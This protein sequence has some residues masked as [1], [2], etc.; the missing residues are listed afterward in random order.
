[1]NK[2][3]YKN[4]FS[5]QNYDRILL[6]I[7]KGMGEEW[8]A[9][10]KRRNMSLNAMVQEAVNQYLL[11]SQERIFTMDISKAITIT[12]SNIIALC[13]RHNITINELMKILSISEQEMS[14]IETTGHTNDNTLDK[15]CKYFD[16]SIGE[17]TFGTIFS[18]I[19]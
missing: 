18:E 6:A 17:L 19:K 3:T 9:E 11:N 16:V 14:D 8:K 4:E 15:I 10:A 1:M 2:T 5:R 7:P 13:K 12:Y